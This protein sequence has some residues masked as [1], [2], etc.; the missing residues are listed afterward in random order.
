MG[1]AETAKEGVALARQVENLAALAEGFVLLGAIAHQQGNADLNAR[2]LGV[3]E[4]LQ[5]RVGGV[6]T[7]EGELLETMVKDTQD[8]LGEKGYAKGIAEGRAMPL[9]VAVDYALRSIH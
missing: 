9:D 3:V 7:D 8:V 1:A 2:L 5:E 4:M 6:F